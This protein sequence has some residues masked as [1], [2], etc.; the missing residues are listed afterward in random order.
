MCFYI[1]H[2][3]IMLETNGNFFVETFTDIPQLPWK[4]VSKIGPPNV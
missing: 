1:G 2:F 4:I 3:Q